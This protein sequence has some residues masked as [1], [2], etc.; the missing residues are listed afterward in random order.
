MQPGASLH[1]R[2]GVCEGLH[3]EPV[4]IRI[5]SEAS[6]IL[7]ADSYHGAGKPPLPARF[8]REKAGVCAGSDFP[9]CPLIPVSVTELRSRPLKLQAEEHIP[10]CL[11]GDIVRKILVLLIFRLQK[12]DAFSQLLIV[13]NMQ[14][15]II[16]RGQGGFLPGLHGGEGVLLQHVRYGELPGDG[17]GHTRSLV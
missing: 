13:G 3:P 4:K 5:L 14:V 6:Q 16:I 10:A 8:V 7:A 2:H 12:S 15:Q 1:A 11:Q 9:Q 17:P